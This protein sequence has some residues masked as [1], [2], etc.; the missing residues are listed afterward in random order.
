VGSKEGKCIKALKKSPK[1]P[2]KKKAA[3]PVWDISLKMTRDE[4]ALKW[5]TTW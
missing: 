2:K 4:A 5:D 3:F 1:L